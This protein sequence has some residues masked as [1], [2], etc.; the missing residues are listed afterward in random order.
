MLFHYPHMKAIAASL[1]ITCLIFAASALAADLVKLEN[2]RWVEHP[3]NDGDSFRAT[4]GQQL[5]YLR[6]YFVDCPETS[7]DS[8]TMARRVRE[9]TRYFGLD[10]HEDT[11]RYGNLATER[12]R[13]WLAQPFT[14]YT[15]HADAMG[16]STLPRIYAF[17]VTADGM[18]LDQLLVKNGLARAYGVGRLD[19]R[20]THRDERKAYLEDLEAAAMLERRGIWSATNPARI[21]DLRADQRRESM[22]LQAIRAELG[23]GGIQEGEIIAINHAGPDALQ[24]LPGIGPALADRMVQ[25]RPFASIDDLTRVPGIGPATVERL[26][27]HLSLDPEP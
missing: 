16:R 25:A 2:L 27:P 12:V 21:A 9:Q 8:E 13:E 11:I 15:T 19:Y 26:R 14:A 10:R 7:A 4:D 20:G 1:Y 23:L 5:W 3:G 18:D 17:V 22:E 24:R 6:L